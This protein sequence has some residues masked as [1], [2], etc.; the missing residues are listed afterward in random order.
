MSDCYI[1]SGMLMLKMSLLF[2]LISCTEPIE[3]HPPDLPITLSVQD[4][5]ITSAKLY[6][7]IDNA[8]AKRHV[9]LYRDGTVV[10]DDRLLDVDTI[11]IDRGLAPNSNYS[12]RA[13]S[14]Y[15]D[16]AVDSS[17]VV[18]LTT[19]N[20]SNRIFTWEVDSIGSYVS[21]LWDVA[22][23]SDDDIWIC[24]HQKIS[25]SGQEILLVIKTHN[26][27][28]WY[29]GARFQRH[30]I[31]NNRTLLSKIGHERCNLDDRIMLSFSKVPLNHTEE[32]IR[33]MYQINAH[34]R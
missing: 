28:S 22:V 29:W 21:V 19:N 11:F 3:P 13:F 7:H 25:P 30:Y 9:Q 8:T 2:Y 23:I 26:F 10:L 4:V 16:E 32:C 5:G 34:A 31:S 12:Y 27:G 33:I 6:I 14:L 1:R 20:P 24:F 17:L 18:Q 15:R